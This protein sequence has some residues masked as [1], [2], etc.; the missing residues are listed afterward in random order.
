M[1]RKLVSGN[2]DLS[3]TERSTL[4]RDKV[5]VIAVPDVSELCGCER[6]ADPSITKSQRP[7]TDHV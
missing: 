7:F 2:G 6:M 5:E 4:S 1:Q 3:F